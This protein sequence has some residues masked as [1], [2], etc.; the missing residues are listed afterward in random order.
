MN[1]AFGHPQSI[2]VLGG[3]SEI[4]GSIIR[5]ELT[6]R[7]ESI[8]LAGR[9][10]KL[11]QGAARRYGMLRTASVESV[12]FD[13]RVDDP[14]QVVDKC[15]GILDRQVDLVVVAVGELGSQ[16]SDEDSA[17]RIEQMIGVNFSWPAAAVAATAR[18]LKAQGQGRI[19]VLTSVAG[20][21]IRRDNFVYGSAKAGLDAFVMGVAEACVGSGVRVHVVRPGFVR[22]KMTRGLTS[23]PFATRP[24]AVAASVLRGIRKDQQIIWAPPGLRW[25]FAVLRLLPKA[26]WRRLSNEGR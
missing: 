11:L 6:E 25:V 10:E 12:L 1:D 20:V 21:R 3:T 8:V 16:R 26:M 19:V 5:S 9:D 2:V 24:D 13:A 18:L 7:C 4:A 15:F 23:A 22:T 14:G 17:S